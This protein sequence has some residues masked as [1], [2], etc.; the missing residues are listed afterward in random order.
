MTAS[1]A[2][3]RGVSPMHRVRGF[4]CWRGELSIEAVSRPVER[5]ET[6]NDIDR[7]ADTCTESRE[8]FRTARN[9][10]ALT[11]EMLARF[12][13]RMPRYDEE[14]RFFTEDFFELRASGYLTLPVTAELGGRGFT[15]GSAT[16]TVAWRGARST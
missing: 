14:N 8:P 5:Q 10:P 6:P 1:Q 4:T 13:E 15:R 7:R 11:D 2:H 3:E 12:S 16:S 9:G